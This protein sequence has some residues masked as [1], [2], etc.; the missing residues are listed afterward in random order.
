[1]FGDHYEC[2]DVNEWVV[3]HKEIYDVAILTEVIEHI[4]NPIEFLKSIMLMLKVGGQLILTTP[5]KT[6]YKNAVWRTDAP[7]VHLWWF[8]ESSMCYIASRINADIDFTDFNK[9]YAKRYTSVGINTVNIKQKPIL[10]KNGEVIKLPNNISL[11]KR[12]RLLLKKISILSIF[13][14]I[15]Y[16]KNPDIYICSKKGITLGVMFFKK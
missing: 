14:R 8:S 7:P 1:M 13:Y 10:N 9:Y 2:A 4:D 3:H 6:I 11:Y 16:R 15:K 5:N 12:F